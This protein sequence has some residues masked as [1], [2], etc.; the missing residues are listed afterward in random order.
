MSKS[1]VALL[2]AFHFPPMGESSGLQRT[3]S[4]ANDLAELGWK[5]IILTVAKRAYRVTRNDQMADIDHR[6]K[7]V[8]A[9]AV[10]ASRTFAIRR[11]YPQFLALPDVWS[12]W[13]IAGSVLGAWLILR[14]RPAF[15]WST[16]PI[17][18]AHVLGLFLAK[19]S[20]KPWIADFRDSMTEDAY[21]RDG[22]QRRV[23]QWIER[24][25]VGRAR[26]CIFT[27]D[28]TLAMYQQRYP[29]S[30]S[31]FRLIP[32]GYEERYFKALDS[33]TKRPTRHK[34]APLV[35]LHSGI[36]YPSE[37]DPT[38]LFEAL[39]MLR[40][41]GIDGRHL[42]IL[43]RAS[44][45]DTEY[46]ATVL[47][48]G[49]EDMVGFLPAIAYQDALREMTEVDYLLVLQA[50]N[51]NHQIPAKI[52]EYIRAGT[53]IVALTDPRGDTARLMFETGSALVA[54]LD[55]AA[56]IFRLLSDLVTSDTG[57][58]SKALKFEIS[59]YSRKAHA[60]SL[61]SIAQAL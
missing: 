34:N 36:I 26:H 15:I 37:R 54:R 43:L 9:F 27:T 3:L 21:P 49:I 18:T 25:V 52:Y 59:Q 29:R 11:K 57:A 55:D 22:T 1:K 14:H 24:A 46:A 33:D 38:Q 35:F 4:L 61:A 41:A 58:G 5:P 2:I 16:Y 47:R 28:G 42:K 19:I 53:P 30:A 39:R 32:N 44:G 23:Y 45:F 6:V 50:S 8:R 13:L 12:S 10:D 20:G 56:E 51:C 17:A 48:F 31:N 40:G 60:A 7:V